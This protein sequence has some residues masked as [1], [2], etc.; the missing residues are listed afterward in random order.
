L[1]RRAP[2]AATTSGACANDGRTSTEQLREQHLAWRES[3]RSA[4]RTTS[5]TPIARSSTT[6]ASW[7]AQMPSPR[8]RTKSPTVAATSSS[9]LLLPAV[10]EPRPLPPARIAAGAV[11]ESRFPRLAQRTRPARPGI[12][13]PLVAGVRRARDARD[14]GARAIAEIGPAGAREDLERVT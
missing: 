4:P 11:G 14:L 7:Y 12:A 6:T 3:S 1:A 8:A 2:S 13:R 5:V 9:D 10:V